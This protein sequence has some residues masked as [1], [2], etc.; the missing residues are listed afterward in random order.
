MPNTDDL[1]RALERTRDETL[2]H[3]LLGDA[4]LARSYAPGKWSVRYVLQHVADSELVF[5]ERLRRAIS[6]PGTVVWFYDQDA[7]SKALD[8]SS[9]PLTLARGVFE[10]LRNANIELARERTTSAMVALEFVHS[11]AGL[12]TVKSESRQGEASHNEHHLA[13]TG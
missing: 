1:I 2:E 9:R 3:Y 10:T 6:E 5:A 13:Q 12:L 7:W 11:K 8:Y 4:D